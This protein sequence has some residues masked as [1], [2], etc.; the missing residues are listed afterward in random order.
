MDYTGLF[1]INGVDIWTTY[2]AYLAETETGHVNA[3]ALNRYPAAKDITTVD[4]RE[5]DGVEL[6]ENPDIRL[7]SIERTLQFAIL[8]HTA[9]NRLQYY[10][11]F[12]QFLSSGILS[13]NVK[14][15][16][17]YNM[18]YQDMSNDPSWY[19]S[20]DGSSYLVIFQVKFLEPDPKDATALFKA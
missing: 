4:F 20:Y 1:T 11:A 10:H 8:T 18:V 9:E 6:P 19:D 17:T 16:R 3:D 15:Y 14:Y 2:R 5:R 13:C 7:K 12:M